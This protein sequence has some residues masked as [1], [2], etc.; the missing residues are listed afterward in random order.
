MS[1]KRDLVPPVFVNVRWWIGYEIVG[2]GY[3][4]NHDDEAQ[5]HGLLTSEVIG[6]GAEN[7]TGEHCG[8]GQ[9]REDDT[10]L[11]SRVAPLFGHGGQVWSQW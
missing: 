5:E 9:H 2:S 3:Q 8:E 10:H 6:Y 7:G 4:N 1:G 11:P